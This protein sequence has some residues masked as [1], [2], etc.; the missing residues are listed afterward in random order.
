MAAKHTIIKYSIKIQLLKRVRQ[1]KNTI[2]YKII[3]ISWL[4]KI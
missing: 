3:E 2:K 4:L 1:I